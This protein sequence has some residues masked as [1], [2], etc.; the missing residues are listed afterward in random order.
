M[1]NQIFQK[2]SNECDNVLCPSDVD[3]LWLTVF[4][5]DDF[6]M[7]VFSAAK[8]IHNKCTVN[9]MVTQENIK[10][11]IQRKGKCCTNCC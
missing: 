5:S 8:S 1:Y 11:N 9:C 10:K 2:V 4:C 7:P 3:K 6:L